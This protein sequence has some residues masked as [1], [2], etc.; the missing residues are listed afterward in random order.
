MYDHI[1]YIYG[2][3]RNSRRDRGKGERNDYY[4][5][6]TAALA[7]LHCTPVKHYYYYGIHTCI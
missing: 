7:Q 1:I 2:S 3:G 5:Q 6:T 4:I